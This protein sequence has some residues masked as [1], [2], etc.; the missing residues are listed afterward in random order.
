MFMDV[1][2]VAIGNYSIMIS[3]SIGYYDINVH[4]MTH[5]YDYSPFEKMNIKPSDEAH[6]PQYHYSHLL[7][8]MQM[9]MPNSLH[10]HPWTNYCC[11]QM[12]PV[13]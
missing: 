6:T 3:N 4:K 9:Q 13:R 7:M 10:P 5:L 11:H 1:I 8:L 12:L 2:I